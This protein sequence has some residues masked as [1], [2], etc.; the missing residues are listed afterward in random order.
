MIFFDT[1]GSRGYFG[2][3][4][5]QYAFTRA[6]AQRL[7][8]AFYCSHWLGDEV[9]LLN[10]SEER[11]PKPLKVSHTYME[12]NCYTGFNKEAA[13]IEDETKIAGFFQ[14]ERY[15][16]RDLIIQWF[17][18]RDD[19]T[20]RVRE[21]Y[22]GIDF[23]DSVGV[24][25]RRGDFVATVRYRILF[26]VPRL[27]YYQKALSCLGPHKNILVFSDDIGAARSYFRSLPGNKVFIEGNENY[28]D[29]YLM[30]QCRD[31]I[32]SASTFS[33]WGAFLNHHPHKKVVAP[34]EGP[35]RPGPFWP[36][37]NLQNNDYLCHDWLTARALRPIVDR[38][39][40]VLIREC[41]KHPY[42]IISSIVKYGWKFRPSG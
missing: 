39:F 35:F 41:F 25:F 5:F 20:A 13:L 23:N 9:F 28:E 15:W 16:N 1:L 7:G 6:T 3:Q 24:H 42:K 37:H 12:P 40:V 32:I 10:D 22:R 31:M 17:R 2:N 30:T 38:C 4:L 36:G 19:K 21:K 27:S 8:V 33:W 11:A 18:F 34:G 29:L 26:Y 14:T